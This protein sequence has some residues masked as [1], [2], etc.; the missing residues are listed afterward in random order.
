MPEVSNT[1]NQQ[2]GH[3]I[4]HTHWDREWRVPVWKSRM[5][6][7]RMMDQL[8]ETI[9]N[10]PNFKSF[11]FDS[12]V[13]GI[14]DYLEFRPENEVRVKQLI[15]E[16]RLQIGP[17]Y[18]LPDEYP[19]CGE[20]LIRNLLVGSNR[21]KEFGGCL[22]VGYLS[23]GWGQTAQLPQ[24]LAGFGMD[25]VVI[26]KNISKKRAPYCEFLWESPDGTKLTATRL[27]DGG[28]ANFYFN[29]VIPAIY[30]HRLQSSSCKLEVQWGQKGWLWHRADSDVYS[31]MTQ[32]PNH[33]WNPGFLENALDDIWQT[34]KDTLVPGHRFLGNGT[35]STV[36]AP[37]I[38][39][40]IDK[41]NSSDE[42]RKVKHSSLQEYA[43]AIKDE[44]DNKKLRLEIIKGELRDGP[45]ADVSGN[46]L[47]TR[48]PLKILN[49][50]AQNQL[51]RYAEPL[52]VLASLFGVEYPGAFVEK[53]WQYL[54]KAH[55]HDAIN[56]VTLDK[57]ANDTEYKLTQVIELSQVIVDH[58]STGILQNVDLS[59]YEKTDVLLAIINPVPRPLQTIIH[60]TIDMPANIKADWLEIE[61]EKGDQLEVQPIL[62]KQNV[63]PVNVEG[64]RA[65]PFFCSRH[66]MYLS[67][68][69]IPACGYKILKIRPVGEFDANKIFW[70]D[71]YDFGTQVNGPNRMEN[72][73]LAVKINQNGTIDLT[74]KETGR[75]YYGLLYFED[76]GDIGDYWQRVP[77]VQDEVINSMTS[78][79]EI[80]LIEDG[81][82]VTS[83]RISL[84]LKVAESGDRINSVRSKNRVELMI[85]SIVTI[86][87]DQP[88]VEIKTTV[89]NR[90]MDHRLRV[91]FPSSIQ[92]DFSAA[93]GHFNVDK[94]PIAQE[95]NDQGV[96]DSQ[97]KTLPMQHFVDLSDRK[98][99]LAVLN[100]TL[101]EYEISRDQYRTIS[102]TLLRC[103]P[104]KIATDHKCATEEPSQHGPQCLGEYTFEYALYPHKGTWESANL[105][106]VT[107]KYIC[108]P[109][110]YQTSVN[111]N[112]DL[113][114]SDTFLQVSPAQL[115]TAAVK[116]SEN[117]DGIVI[118]VYNPTDEMIEGTIVLAKHIKSAFEANLDESNRNPL[119]ISEDGIIKLKVPGGKISTIILFVK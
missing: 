107:E 6:L 12:Q 113:P 56:G 5:R 79:A 38:D 88:Y 47:A 90:A 117:D 86:R 59:C 41:L 95:I 48:M 102:L 57:T 36:L 110:V 116:K 99:G 44:I 16:G 66:T 51:I 21:A 118:R 52:A 1:Q 37:F 11:V 108:P 39:Q 9:E 2:I 87:A 53:A 17:W 54:L 73:Y 25:F 78:R 89:Q 98:E 13:I 42:Q 61:D 94:R 64:R 80:A 18:N 60:V 70:H 45:A 68:G 97:M 24:I 49:R 50:A 19:V 112:G 84:L 69:K 85:S 28:R 65:L 32:V 40:I 62:N 72:K 76:S 31:E 100:K 74:N 33:E 106:D 7:V 14:E 115:Q 26:G 93:Q 55:S 58:A 30:G 46:A 63:S 96:Y 27:G 20:A 75:V 43:S 29:A 111:D 119:K 15:K 22:R 10:L 92:T 71:H 101:T 34:T 8:L 104:V 67:T 4:T 83:Y 91:C 103:V 109:C 3:I 114:L 81:P 23:F 35:D 105:Y 82:L 77:P